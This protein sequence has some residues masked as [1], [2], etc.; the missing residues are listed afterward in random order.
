MCNP[1]L[2]LVASTAVGAVGQVQAASANAA[3]S[4]YSAAVNDQNARFAEKRARDALERGKEEENRVR[5]EGAQL[6]G[7]QIAGMAAAGLDLSFGSPMDI[8]IDTTTGIELDAARVRRNA[9]LEYDD[10]MRQGWSYKANAGMD[11]AS[12]ANAKSAGRLAVVGTVLGGVGDYQKYKA[13]I[14]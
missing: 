11:R 6:K 13:S 8:L 5:Q 9:D 10:N 14:A 1:A 12:A 3:A 2:L 7:N 4:N